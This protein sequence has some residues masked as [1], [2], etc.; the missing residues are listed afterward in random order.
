MLDGYILL[1]ITN[2]KANLSIT[3]PTQDK[4]FNLCDSVKYY[5]DWAQFSKLVLQDAM[6]T[7]DYPTGYTKQAFDYF[8]WADCLAGTA[9]VAEFD[10]PFVTPNAKKLRDSQEG[11]YSGHVGTYA[12]KIFNFGKDIYGTDGEPKVKGNNNDNLETKNAFEDKALGTVEYFPNKDP[13]TNHRWEWTLTADEVEY[14]TK[15]KAADEPVTVSRWIRFQAKTFT[16]ANAHLAAG[17]LAYTEDQYNAPYPY[18]WIKLTMTITRDAL[19]AKYTKKIDNFWFN[20]NTGADDGWSGYLVDIEAPRDEKTI[21][22][23]NWYGFISHT[24][25]TNVPVLTKFA[26]GTTALAKDYQAGKYYFAPKTYQI[27][28]VSGRKYTI[29]PQRSGK[30]GTND[31]NTKNAT[32]YQDADANW[33]KLVN[34][35]IVKGQKFAKTP[36]TEQATVQVNT[37]TYTWDE[38]KLNEQLTKQAIDLNK[39]VFTNDTLYAYWEDSK[40][41]NGYYTPIAAIKRQKYNVNDNADLKNTSGEIV[42]FHWLDAAKTGKGTETNNN[43][44]EQENWVCYDVLN[45][46]GYAAGNANINKQLRGWLGFVGALCNDKVAYYV[47]Q[48]QFEEPNKATVLSS[49]ERPINLND[50]EKQGAIDAKTQENTIYMVDNLKL[51][52]WRGDKPIGHM[53]DNQYWFWAYYNV[54]GAAFVLDGD[55]VLVDLYDGNGFV[56][57]NTVTS[58]LRLTALAGS[59]TLPTDFPYATGELYSLLQTAKYYDFTAQNLVQYNR[60][61]KEAAI[62]AALGV[63]PVNKAKKAKFGGIY[64]EN[65][66]LNVTKFTLKIPVAVRY[67]WGWLYNQTFEWTIDTTQGH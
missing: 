58:K 42:L 57:L 25:F 28:G 24:L 32:G 60:E 30:I 63:N 3:Y 21:K 61:D 39:G 67:E 16:E 7:T 11:Q 26:D 2:T 59:T 41:K 51:F 47:E 44:G 6:K 52:D 20:Y 29:T 37:D 45:A 43:Y 4:K 13:Q 27:T 65:D 64:Y 9:A 23:N 56:K 18:I 15:G 14:L 17:K 40:G 12:M 48:A 1:R 33:N 50:P 34:K 54:M 55:K 62:E 10:Q 5:T 31:K 36:D 8:Y 46:I 19:T 66:A 35:Y 49:W 22:D 38:A 53:Y